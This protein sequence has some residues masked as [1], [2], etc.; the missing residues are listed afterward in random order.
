MPKKRGHHEGNYTPLPDGRVQWKV[1]VTYPDGT[2]NR[3]SGTARN[4]TAARQA[5]RDAQKNA[6]VGVRPVA[7]HLT[8]LEMVTEYMEA[9]RATWSYRT[10]KNNEYLL[11]QYIRE[12]LG[13]LRAAGVT[14]RALRDYLGAL[15]LGSS[16]QNQVRSLLSG[17]YKRAIAD[18]LLRDNPTVHA[19]VVKERRA[20]V[21]KAFAPDEARRFYEA[22]LADRWAWPLAFMLLTGLRIGE[23][24]AL[25]WD[26]L[27]TEGGDSGV[28]YVLV[29]K[30][31]SEYQ[32]KAYENSPKTA[33][34]HRKVYLSSDAQVLV[35]RVRERAKLEAEAHGR[36]VGPS[37][38][39]SP[40]TGQPCIHDSLRGVMERTCRLAEVP[41][42]T[43]H[44]LRH[45]FTS[46]MHA[47]G[48]SL[49]AISAHLGHAQ[50]STTANIYRSIFDE[51]RRG[52]TL[53]LS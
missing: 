46:L 27:H 13:G 38:F 12:Q 16:G 24:V 41:R 37:I 50:V 48:G 33:A 39:P 11:E 45:S 25:T 42:L 21:Q 32:G 8:V 5:V 40:L 51:E 7:K 36:G 14:P 18:G 31:R 10:L 1:R 47:Q 22:A 35:E 30:T 43:P 2:G 29:N 4:M 28:A 53:N 44:G 17:A 15:S 34:G 20:P 9:K 6:E 26:D 23:A 52:V 19:P 49:A 3:P